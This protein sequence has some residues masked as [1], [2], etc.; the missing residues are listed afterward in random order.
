[1][2]YVVNRAHHAEIG[3]TRPGS[4]PPAARRLVE[5]GV[6]IPPFVLIRDGI[7]RWDALRNLLTTA[8]Y[9]SRAVD[10]NL[11]DLRAQVAA[12]QRG[13]DLLCELAA[14]HGAMEVRSRMAL[15]TARSERL[16]R[17]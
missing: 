13:A 12:N 5:E 2:G 8:P 6:T 16:L 17:A 10:E 14:A 9:P 7:A 11:A 3:G 15:L 4:M 1:L